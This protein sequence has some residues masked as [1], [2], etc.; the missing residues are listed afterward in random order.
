MNKWLSDNEQGISVFLLNRMYWTHNSLDTFY[1]CQLSIVSKL[2]PVVQSF[3]NQSHS[4]INDHYESDSIEFDQ[5]FFLSL[6]WRTEPRILFLYHQSNHCSR[7]RILF[8]HQSN[9]RSRF[10]FFLSMNKSLYLYDLDVSYF[11]KKWFDW[12]DLVW[13][14]WDR[15]YR[16]DWY[17]N[18]SS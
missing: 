14:L 10:F 18:I 4:L 16:W 5:S 15:W 1:E 7:P 11:S 3:D 12:W 2:L 6:R 8:Y 13:Y 17:S 9:H